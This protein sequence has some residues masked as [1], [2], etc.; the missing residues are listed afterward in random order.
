MYVDEPYSLNEKS[1]EA[2]YN[3][4]KPNTTNATTVNNNGIS[5]THVEFLDGE[6]DKRS[7]TKVLVPIFKPFS[8][9]FKILEFI[10]TGAARRKQ[11]D[12][13]RLGNFRGFEDCLMQSTCLSDGKARLS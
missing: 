8:A 4:I 10:V 9:F 6:K 2:E 11:Y 5:T 3:M 13:T 12:I 1:N 7:F